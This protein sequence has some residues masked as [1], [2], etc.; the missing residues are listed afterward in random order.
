[1]R[2]TLSAPPALA[3][4]CCGPVAALVSTP[5]DLV[6][7]RVAL[8]VAPSAIAAA[9]EL[10][11]RRHLYLG[12]GINTTR[13]CVFLAAYFGTYEPAKATLSSLSTEQQ[14]LYAVPLAGSLAGATGW[15][16]SYP[17][18]CVKTNVQRVAL[19]APTQAGGVAPPP[20]WWR[21]AR[22][23]VRERSLVGLYAG[24]GPSVARAC[25]VSATR[26]SAYELALQWLVG[27]R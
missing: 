14:P 13:E 27:A 3:G 21:V 16:V 9:R 8:G 26:F 4:A 7:V 6:K 11:A 25:V 20:P 12:H 18:D 23:L 1:V 2:R 15:L 5:F 10:L 19:A 17:L 22:E 24:V